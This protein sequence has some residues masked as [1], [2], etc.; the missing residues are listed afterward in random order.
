MKA[1]GGNIG[2]WAITGSTL[3]CTT[4]DTLVE[5]SSDVTSG[6]WEINPGAWGNTHA[7]FDNFNAHPEL[8]KNFMR[9]ANTHDLVPQG[10]DIVVWKK[11]T[12]FLY[13]HVAIATGE[14]NL[15]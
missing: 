6:G 12:G 3:E 14:G 9:I 4:N 1:T 5:I 8:T 7:Y 15:K 2:G 13:G 11:G 10:G